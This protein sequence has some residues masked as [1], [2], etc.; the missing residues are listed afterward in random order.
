MH[1]RAAVVK[2]GLVHLARK[3]GIVSIIACSLVGTGRLE[4]GRTRPGNPCRHSGDVLLRGCSAFGIG[5]SD[6]GNHGTV[7]PARDGGTGNARDFTIPVVLDGGVVHLRGQVHVEG[8]LHPLLRGAG[9]R[10][11]V[12]PAVNPVCLDLAGHLAGGRNRQ[13][14][15]D[16]T[17]LFR[18]DI[19]GELAL[20]RVVQGGIDVEVP[21]I[22]DVVA[23]VHVHLEGVV[24]DSG[25]VRV[26][27]ERAGEVIQVTTVHLD[28][29]YGG[30]HGARLVSG[31][32]GGPAVLLGTL[33]P[34][35]ELVGI[36]G[37]DAQVELGDTAVVVL[38]N[39]D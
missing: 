6:G 15:V 34:F 26:H 20:H 33:D 17:I 3:A 23:A 39:K 37:P 16:Y 5:G 12:D 2:S 36:V 4:H 7:D 38:V 22:D 24:V 31:Y 18:D 10:D 35:Q 11:R 1:S 13:L 28:T 29:L 27:V 21:R 25:A 32:P 8:F 30:L 19:R 14:E 9:V